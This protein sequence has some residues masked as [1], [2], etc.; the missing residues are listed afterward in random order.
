VIGKPTVGI[1]QVVFFMNDINKGNAGVVNGTGGT[2]VA[3]NKLL[4]PRYDVTF[5]SIFKSKDNTDVIAD[6]LKAVLEISDGEDFEDIIVTDPELL[7]VA[8]GEKF[9]ILDVLLKIRGKG[10]IN[11]EM[12]FCRIQDMEGRLVHYWSKI[13]SRQ[14]SVGESYSNFGKVIMIVIAD[15][16]FIDDPDNYYHRYLLYDKERDS[17][18]TDLMEFVIVETRKV[19]ATPDNTAKW[20]WARFFGSSSDA[21][22]REAAK[23]SEKIRKAMLTIEKLSADENAR[24]RADYEEI[25]RLDHITR[26]EGAKREGRAERDAEIARRM[27]ELGS[28]EAEIAKIL[29]SDKLITS[30]SDRMKPR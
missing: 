1:G 13:A 8:D 20:G 29:G 7:P 11:V 15:F 30:V 9:S 28:T 14:L 23:E 12:Q 24:V 3:E 19:P 18:F 4:L 25:M 6:F 5:K 16:N 22:L 21:E 2:G 17:L 26:M 27:A 10:I